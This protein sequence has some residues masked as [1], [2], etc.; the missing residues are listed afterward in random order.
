MPIY[1]DDL[2]NIHCFE[3]PPGRIVSLVP[4]ITRTIIDLGA[5]SL[6][7]GRTRYCIQPSPEV[8]MI[9]TV[10]G[11]KKVNLKKLLSL[12]PDIVL[13]NKEENTSEMYQAIQPHVPF[14]T[15]DVVTLEDNERLIRQLGE[16]CGREQSASEMIGRV[17]A[18]MEMMADVPV[19]KGR[20]ALY[21]IWKNPWMS[22]GNDTFIHHVLEHLGL[23]SV[24]AH[25]SRY[26][27]IDDKF[28]DLQPDWVFFSSE[29]YPFGE[30]DFAD[31]REYF[32]NSKFLLVSGEYFS[33]YGSQME[34]A[35]RYFREL[36]NQVQMQMPG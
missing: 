4:S 23:K 36:A 21:L 6:L 35:G 3:H 18:S 8:D 34:D 20:K 12:K 29:P 7:V 31:L 2:G 16:I 19:F 11:T 33:W 1:K 28:D 32:P 13:G 5:G 9:P 24:T 15:S 22:V 26:P 25:L 30:K 10:G 17:K 27:V 14:W